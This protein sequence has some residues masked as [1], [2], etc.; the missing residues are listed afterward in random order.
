MSAWR[1]DLHC[2]TAERGQLQL[3][4]LEMLASQTEYQLALHKSLSEL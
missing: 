4:E 2:T 3:V 1:T